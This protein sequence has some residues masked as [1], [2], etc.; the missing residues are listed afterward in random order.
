[1]KYSRRELQISQ[2]GMN[3]QK[4]LCLSCGYN[5][6][7]LNRKSDCPEC[8]FSIEKTLIARNGMTKRDL[9]MLAFRVIAV[10]M[11]VDEIAETVPGYNFFR[12]DSLAAAIRLIIWLLVLAILAALWW[13]APWLAKKAVPNDGPITIGRMWR[14]KDVMALAMSALGIVLMTWGVSGFGWSFAQ[15][16]HDGN[17]TFALPNLVGSLISFAIGAFLLFGAGIFVR[18]IVWLRVAGMKR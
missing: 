3:Y 4:T 14:D 10:W 16:L 11:I 13:K 7:G 2:I 8:G 17:S 9:A 5:L 12:I 6:R 15:W 18:F 1:M